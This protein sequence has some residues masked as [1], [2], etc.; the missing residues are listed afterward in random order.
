[1][2]II[3][4]MDYYLPHHDQPL[5]FPGKWRSEVVASKMMVSFNR[6]WRACCVLQKNKSPKSLQF[7]FK[8]QITDQEGRLVC[9]TPGAPDFRCHIGRDLAHSWFF[10]VSIRDDDTSEDAVGQEPSKCAIEKSGSGSVIG[11]AVRCYVSTKKY[12]DIPSDQSSSQ[13][14]YL[15]SSWSLW[16]HAHPCHDPVGLKRAPSVELMVVVKEIHDNQQLPLPQC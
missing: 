6:R 10:L 1:M 15:L 13:S 9:L 5:L 12:Q 2:I 3:I 16:T 11:P 8:H 4:T 14:T 7:R